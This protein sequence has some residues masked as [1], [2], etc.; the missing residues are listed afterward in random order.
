MKKISLA[1]IIATAPMPAF[2]QTPAAPSAVVEPIDESRLAAAKPVVDRL[3]P[4]GTYRRM[5]D[6]TMSKLIDSMMDSMMGMRAADLVGP[7]DKSGGAAKTMGNRSMGE[8]ASESD[9]HFRER[10]KIMM[11][12]MMGEM[13]PI[14]ER[15]EPQIRENMSTIYARKFS[16]SQLGDMATFFATPTG[17]IFAEQSMLVFM[18]PEM[19]QGMQAFMPELMKAMP[20]MMKKVEAATAHLPMPNKPKSKN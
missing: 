9:P 20:G 17:K 1:L 5:M 14:M 12:T 3:W 6:G 8:I 7:V 10:M 2:A 16:V 15:L 19:I 11:D 13:L 18:E 4:L